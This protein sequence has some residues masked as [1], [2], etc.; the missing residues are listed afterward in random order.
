MSI[1]VLNLYMCETM[2]IYIPT[3]C[4]EYCALIAMTTMFDMTL[5]PIPEI[6][7]SSQNHLSHQA[8]GRCTGIRMIPPV[9]PV[10]P[11]GDHRASCP[12]QN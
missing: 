10:R 2:M 8:S 6:T 4:Y 7:K 12:I 9:N 1:I 3:T 5:V 11:L